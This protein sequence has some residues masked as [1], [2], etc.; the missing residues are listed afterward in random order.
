VIADRID[1]TFLVHGLR[2]HPDAAVPPDHVLEDLGGPLAGVHR[3]RDGLEGRRREVVATLDQPDQLV[4][5]RRRL[6]H[7]SLIA[8]ERQDVPAQVKLAADAALELPEHRVLGPGE[9]GGDRV[10]DGELPA[11]QAA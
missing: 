11:S 2:R 5:D 1:V 6:T 9:L 3:A 4:Y 10:V 7:L 8:V